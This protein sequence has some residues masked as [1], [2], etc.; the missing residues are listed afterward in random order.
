MSGRG[1]V[2]GKDSVV[3]RCWNLCDCEAKVQ[4]AGHATSVHA[5][6]FLGPHANTVASLDVSGGIHVWSKDTGVSLADDN[7]CMLCGVLLQWPAVCTAAVAS[8][9]MLLQ[10]P[11]A[12][13]H[14]LMRLSICF[15]CEDSTTWTFATVTRQRSRPPLGDAVTH[16]TALFIFT[17]LQVVVM[18]Q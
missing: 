10:W 5:I 4:Y 15:F 8:C 14:K 16:N 13:C 11:A 18:T 7:C 2:S 17:L 6:M 12:V 3:V 1:Q 9:S